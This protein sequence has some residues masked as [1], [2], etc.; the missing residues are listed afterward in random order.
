MRSL[1]WHFAFLV[2][3]FSF[4][5]V[6]AAFLLSAAL[7][8]QMD[9]EQVVYFKGN[10]SV[11]AGPGCTV[12]VLLPFEIEKGWHINADRVT[13][14]FMVPSILEVEPPAGTKVERIVY[15][16]AEMVK[17]KIS[18]KPLATW[19]GRIE[20]RVDLSGLPPS[21]AL[22]L[23]GKLTCQACNDT[24][25]LPPQ[26]VEISAAVKIA[27]APMPASGES[28]GPPNVIAEWIRTKGL[29]LALVLIFLSGLALNLTPCV[30]PMIPITLGFFAR[31]ASQGKTHPFFLSFSYFL[32]LTITYSIV[33]LTAALTGSLFGNMMQK[34]FVLIIVAAVIVTLALSLFGLFTIQAP[35]GLTHLA[36]TSVDRSSGRTGYVQAALMGAMVGLVAAPC[37]GPV[38]LALLTFITAAGSPFL[39]FI[40]FFALSCGLGVPY[41]FLGFFSQKLSKLPRS[42]GWMITIERFFGFL[43]LGVALFMLKPLL[44]GS[45]AAGIGALLALTAMVFFF[46]QVIKGSKAL[47]IVFGLLALGAALA[48][49]LPLFKAGPAEEAHDAL[50][51]PYDRGAVDQAFRDGIPVMIDFAADWC[52]PCKEMEKTT[53]KDAKVRKLLGQFAVFRADLTRGND[54]GVRRLSE[55]FSI[56]G[57][58]TVVF[59]KKGEEL[60]S[61]RQAGYVGAGDFAKVLEEALKP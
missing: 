42:G 19:K 14:D 41:L 18:E 6:V 47:N 34:P 29:F 25:C 2:S 16:P 8:A 55:E 28:A 10:F 17:L 35:S 26:D 11:Q 59:L 46:L 32:G 53:F 43:L 61:L 36:A 22:D 51:K 23:K 7:F 21:G 56:R 40:T 15:P 31:K 3:R 49:G 48:V 57:V 39:G 45:V 37:I 24:L 50:F 44:P 13:D 12:S 27:S 33:G 4:R 54:E 58:P 1:L 60:K 5:L 52:I 38:V 9:A 20:I 30:Y